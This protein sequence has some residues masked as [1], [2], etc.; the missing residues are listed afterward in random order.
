M[1][2]NDDAE[3]DRRL[4]SRLES[5]P[6]TIERLVRGALS[7]P[8]E[9][10]SARSVFYRGALV[11]AAVAAVVLLFVHFQSP[12]SEIP[13]RLNMNRAGEM[14]LLQAPSGESWIFSAG[15]SAV[16]LPPGMGLVIIE[17]DSK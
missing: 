8:A 12:D 10:W 11:V 2:R 15:E 1:P 4:R 3:Y 5:E 7:P 6:A 13:D 16:S 14:V 9:R 17:G